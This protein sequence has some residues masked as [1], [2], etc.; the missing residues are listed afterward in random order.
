[1]LAKASNVELPMMSGLLKIHYHPLINNIVNGNINNMI[2]P[3]DEVEFKKGVYEGF[4]Y[5]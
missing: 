1:M 4:R 2:D 3:Y 5:L